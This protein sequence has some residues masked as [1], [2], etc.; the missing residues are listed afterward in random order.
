MKEKQKQKQYPFEGTWKFNAGLTDRVLLESG[1]AD[2][3]TIDRIVADPAKNAGLVQWCYYRHS[4]GHAE[5]L[6]L[7]DGVLGDLQTAL[8]R[9]NESTCWKKVRC[10]DTPHLYALDVF[11]FCEEDGTL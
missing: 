6:S 2:E 1:V 7:S 11:L 3:A 10:E 9:D 5:A 4:E 8:S